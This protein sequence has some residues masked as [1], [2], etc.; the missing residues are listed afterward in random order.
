MIGIVA[1]PLLPLWPLLSL[2]LR[3]SVNLCPAAGGLDDYTWQDAYSENSPGRVR[4][5]GFRVGA[6]QNEQVNGH[7]RVAWTTRLIKN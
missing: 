1:W 4:K 3:S 7:P 5:P 6:V 2:L